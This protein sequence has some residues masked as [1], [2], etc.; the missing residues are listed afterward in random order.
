MSR[1]MK[2]SGV[3]W[4]GEIPEEWEI[5]KLK[6]LLQIPMQ[7]GANETGIEYDEKLPRYIRITDIT[8]DNQLKNTGKLSLSLEQAKG[9]YLRQGDILFARSGATVG[10]TFIY[11]EKYGKCAFAGY[12]I[13]ASLKENVVSKFIYYFTLSSG[14]EMWKNMIFVQATIQNIGAEKYS[15][16]EI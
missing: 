9:Y 1:K 15:N 11:E 6:H 16:L 7:Y 12:L 14:Y 3:E 13:R 10:K 2:D 8:N 5:C 4:I